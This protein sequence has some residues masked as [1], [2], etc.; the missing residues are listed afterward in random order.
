MR[1]VIIAAL[2][3]LGAVASLPHAS[4]VPGLLRPDDLPGP[5]LFAG[6]TRNGTVALPGNAQ[7]PVAHGTIDQ[8]G[9]HAASAFSVLPQVMDRA[10]A[11][12]VLALM[13]TVGL[14]RLD[15]DPDTVDGMPT[16]E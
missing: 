10:T 9:N 4:P 11:G 2:A 14:D 7:Q 5:Q 16:Y 13:R 8:P 1:L 15:S 6:W 12:K 3:G